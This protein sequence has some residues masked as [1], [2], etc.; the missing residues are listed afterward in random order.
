MKRRKL[1]DGK[2]LYKFLKSKGILWLYVQRCIER[3][4]EKELL[5]KNG[6]ISFLSS[7]PCSCIALSFPWPKTIEGWQYWNE[8]NDEYSCFKLKLET[9]MDIIF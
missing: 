5:L 2:A 1:S 7:W 8:I 4:L 9:D 6:I 3:H